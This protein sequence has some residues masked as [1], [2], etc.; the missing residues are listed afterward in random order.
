MI[1][2]AIYGVLARW[3]FDAAEVHFGSILIMTVAF[4]FVVPIVIGYLT[5]RPIDNPTPRQ[6][7]FLPWVPALLAIAVA[8]LVGWEGSICVVLGAPA[9]LVG[10]T[11][12]GALGASAGAR[13]S[14]VTPTL[15]ALPFLLAPIESLTRPAAHTTESVVEIE[16]A[17]PPE[18]VWPLVVSVDSITPAEQR[19][20]LY[21]RLGFPKPV[22]ATIDGSG[23]GAVR[24]AR[25]EGGLTFTETVTN[26]IPDSLLSFTIRPN[27]ES[28]PPT[29]LDPHV[30]VGG[31]F[32]DVLTGT[33]E[34]RRI[35]ASHTLLR[36]TSE[37]RVSTRFNAYSGWWADRIMRSI[38][39]NILEVHR[40][41]AERGRSA[42]AV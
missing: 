42:P 20:A 28:I 34:L 12:G 18:V 41:R 38:Q 39:A 14:A 29:T 35:G 23:V 1:S 3:L 17:A 32:F 22:S 19:P 30:V 9:I 11:M 33:Y 31:P 24:R 15:I 21:T 6:R 25:F 2:A 40:R 36:L 5:V 27:T 7:V 8:M 26:W 10:A 13:R 16:I 4:V 37:H